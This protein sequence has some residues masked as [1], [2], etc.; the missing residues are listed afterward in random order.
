MNPALRTKK[1]VRSW[2]SAFE[3]FLLGCLL[4]LAVN[5]ILSA[6]LSP[7]VPAFGA[8]T[9]GHWKLGWL[10]VATIIIFYPLHLFLHQQTPKEV[11]RR[12]L[13]QAAWF[14]AVAVGMLCITLLY[15]IARAVIAAATLAYAA[16]HL[17]NG[18]WRRSFKRAWV[19]VALAVSLLFALLAQSPDPETICFWLLVPLCWM[20]WLASE[21]VEGQKPFQVFARIVLYAAIA[22]G[23]VATSVYGGGGG[24]KRNL[25]LH[26]LTAYTFAAVALGH[27]LATISALPL[28]A[29]RPLMLTLVATVA[30]AMAIDGMRIARFVQYDHE[31]GSIASSLRAHHRVSE[32][33]DLEGYT[34]P[35]GTDPNWFLEPTKT[36]GTA[37]DC[38]ASIT[39][40]HDVS[41]HAHSMDSAPFKVELGRFIRQRGRLAADHCLACHAPLGVIAFPA[42]GALP[43]D[44]LTTDEPAFRLGVGC[45]VCHRAEATVPQDQVKNASIAVKP[46]WLDSQWPLSQSMSMSDFVNSNLD[47]HRQTFRVDNFEPVC[48]ACHVVS[49]PASL[50]ADHVERT[51]IDQYTS[52]RRSPYAREG[53][54]C[55]SCHQQMFVNSDGYAVPGHQYLGSGASLPYADETED[56][57]LRA[58]SFG[59]LAGIGS[60]DMDISPHALPLCLD[61]LEPKANREPQ[62]S[63]KSRIRH[64]IDPGLFGQHERDATNPFSGTNGGFSRRDLLAVRATL[65]SL[66]AATARLAVTTTNFC[67]GHSF[68]SG[69]GIKGYLE[70]TAYDAKARSVGGYGGL[71]PDGLPIQLPTTLGVNAIDANGKVITD[72]QY[73]NAVNVAYRRVLEPGETSE[74]IIEVRLNEG[75]RP[76]RFD[77]RWNYL[78]PEELRS[79]ERGLK[80]TLTPVLVGSTTIQASTQ[81]P[82]EDAALRRMP[83]S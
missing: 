20:Y 42:S 9:I 81:E 13:G 45:V 59:F 66:D 60:I 18:R 26:A 8:I 5:P 69:E 64:G 55:A 39:M 46:L 15:P 58:I 21:V 62:A 61:D 70:V 57:R 79:R 30:V 52:F 35:T 22:T 53:K 44:P 72:R 73:W 17:R 25:M 2:G 23:M 34:T 54:T 48:G 65:I 14:L 24:A 56:R 77:V 16:W 37:L 1:A 6:V 38:H 7:Y 43:V 51:T 71:G 75:A 10:F 47:S 76:T 80:S 4:W 12:L 67:I 29:R 3:G 27:A 33:S 28:P 32:V 68:P 40:Q 74:D 63:S 83:P 82:I 41:A 36:C 78:R 11:A 50:A 49:L 19:A 31:Q